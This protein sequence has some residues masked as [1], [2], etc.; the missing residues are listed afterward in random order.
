M[1]TSIKKSDYDFLK[2]IFKPRHVAVVGVSADG[3]GFGRGILLSLLKIGFNGERYQVNPRVG[4]TSGLT[5]Y[6]H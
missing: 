6:Q 3:F 5:I 4:T 1:A 2:R